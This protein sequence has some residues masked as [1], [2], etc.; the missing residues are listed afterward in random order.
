MQ[1]KDLDQGIAGSRAALQKELSNPH[2]VA[3]AIS[4]NIDLSDASIR[5]AVLT[6]AKRN[7]ELACIGASAPSA[8][9]V[10]ATVLG[11]APLSVTKNHCA[12][13]ALQA[14]GEVASL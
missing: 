7:L 13:K 5:N 3:L 9:N 14:Y 11:F 10:V 4:L 12:T 6:D 2:V 1:A 8:T